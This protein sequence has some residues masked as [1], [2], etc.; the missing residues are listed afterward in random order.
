MNHA[1]FEPSNTPS[2]DNRLEQ[3]LMEI[4]NDN[5]D[6]AVMEAAAARVWARLAATPSASAP[7]H[8]R[9]CADFQA[10]IPDYRAHRLSEARAALVQDHLH[11]CVACRRV[12]EGRVVAMPAPAPV[13][14]AAPQWRWAAAAVV[15]LAA[16]ATVWYTVG[17]FGG[18][19]GRALVQSV[20][21][22]LFVLAAD[23]TLRPLAAG[24][25]LPEG[26]EVR[27]AKDSS[28]MLQL[29]DGSL[30][31]LRERSAVSASADA[32]DL[33][34]HLSRG[35]LIVQAAKRRSGHL[36]VATADCRVAVTGTVFSV[37][38]GVK[39][40]RVSVLE[41]EVHVSQEN[42]ERVLHP[43]DQL[44]TSP[45][46]EPEPLHEDIGWSQNRE[47]L[48]EQLKKLGVEIRQIHL[49]AVR[50]QSR[51]LGRL[52]A[53][54]AL[55]VS[56]PNLGEYL[57]QAQ[58]VFG[59]N[60][61][62]SPE[63]RDW[64]ASRS[65]SVAP[66]VEK[67]RAASEYLGDEVVAVGMAGPHGLA[68]PAFLAETRRE[69]FPEFVKKNVPNF[70]VAVRPGLVAFGPEKAS[71]EALLAGL[72]TTSPAFQATPFYGRIADAYRQG[73][74]MLLCV[75]LSREPQAEG[76]AGARFLVIGHKEVEQHTEVRATVGFNGERSGIAG[77]LAAPAAM[78][79]L[80]YV[81]P[82][83]TFVAA[84]VV[85]DPAA[86]VEQVSTLGRFAGASSAPAQ[87]SPLRDELVSSLGGEFSVSFDGPIFPPSWKLVAEVYD[88]A[89]ARDAL[90]K[91]VDSYNQDGAREGRK[92][93]RTGEETV[94]GRTYYMIA[95]ADPNPL[96]EAH[97]TFADGYLIAGPTRALVAK[98]LETRVAGASVT[99]SAK[100]VAMQPRDRF[101]N[102]SA[103]V[104]ENFGK[105]LAPIA[106]LL[107]SFAPPQAQGGHGFP[108]DKLGDIKP[109]LIA[110]YAAPDQITFA[111]NAEELPLSDLLAGNLAGMF[112]KAMALGPISS[113]RRR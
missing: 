7:E 51:L 3:A 22:T 61:E 98:A 84:F 77:W 2:A 103:L 4:R 60:L 58:A 15:V 5:V 14:R 25:D 56:V 75:D 26:A 21:G 17:P 110:A 59:R 49:P 6:E 62:Q 76:P 57:G 11:T 79:S 86:I 35:N 87:P 70:A 20:H 73:A 36:Y 18:G 41:G 83:A 47:H 106:G 81:S 109:L 37:V 16:G 34:L 30:V 90:R 1:E 42:Q 48:M 45:S 69:G 66:M 53:D 102:Y 64:W 95:A 52:P 105:T 40:S 93:L 10:L 100:F 82:E 24:Q 28:A 80:D 13:R 104:Y 8:L 54:T 85:R 72:D 94:D 27:T 88:P 31:E 108:V 74:G 78:G 33:T 12:D 91:I 43:G 23:G 32:R 39:G 9:T 112:G 99:H 111:A 97:Y 101:A 50:Y 63:L 65:A 89:R 55:F 68:A 29:R 46:I 107:G 113:G 44:A 67:M 92:P 19:S 71:V 38:S 96:T